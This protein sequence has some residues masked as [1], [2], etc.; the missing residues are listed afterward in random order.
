M[1]VTS[2]AWSALTLRFTLVTG[3]TP[4]TACFCSSSALDTR[5]REWDET[6]IELVGTL[7]EVASM[8]TLSHSNDLTELVH[9]EKEET[10]ENAVESGENG[11]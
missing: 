7:A 9:K 8:E 5:P 10:S 11:R 6:E 1:L 3:L 2:G 4:D